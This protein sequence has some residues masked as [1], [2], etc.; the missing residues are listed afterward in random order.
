LQ[1]RDFI[2][3]I[4]PGNSLKSQYERE[5]KQGTLKIDS[6]LSDSISA[7]IDVENCDWNAKAVLNFGDDLRKVLFEGEIGNQ[8]ER[9]MKTTTTDQGLRIILKTDPAYAKYPWEAI[10][11]NETPFAINKIT[12]II[13]GLTGCNKSVNLKDKPL[14]IL[15]IASSPVGLSNVASKN[16]INNI[17]NEMKNAKEAIDLDTEE[18]ATRENIESKIKKKNYNII[19]FIGHGDFDSRKQT[20]YLAL[21]KKNGRPDLASETEI[22]N[23]FLN[24][25]TV[26]LML[27]NACETA[28]ISERLGNGLVPKLIERVPAIISMRTR[29]SADASVAFTRGCYLN[30]LGKSIEETIQEARQSM[31]IN[32]YLDKDPRDFSIPLLF[33][34]IDEYNSTVGSKHGDLFYKSMALP[35]PDISLR[36]LSTKRDPAVD[37]LGK[38]LDAIIQFYPALD[39]AL[40]ECYPLTTEEKQSGKG[41]ELVKSGRRTSTFL[42]EKVEEL[43]EQIRKDFPETY[44]QIIDDSNRLESQIDKLKQSF[45]KM[46]ENMEDVDKTLECVRDD[47]KKLHDGTV[48]GIL[49]ETGKNSARG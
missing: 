49:R 34:G 5:E 38:F 48:T 44:K 32:D 23:I 28:E 39:G 46:I 41:F 22:K 7:F 14:T 6:T 45:S 47:I 18:E 17:Q 26:G 12:P 19:H 8:F 16:E 40:E 2:I 1:Y 29:I 36:S 35:Q 20:G 31:F 30:L 13:R 11:N 9:A 4:G 42:K 25:E 10:S 3:E 15:V 33:L 27:L 21:Q 24:Q 37:V 43:V